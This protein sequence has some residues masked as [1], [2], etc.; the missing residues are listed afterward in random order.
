MRSIVRKSS[1]V[2]DTSSINP[3]SDKLLLHVNKDLPP[4]SIL[5]DNTKPTTH[6]DPNDASVPEATTM[7]SFNVDS[8][9]G[10]VDLNVISKN[11]IEEETLPMNM[12]ENGE[13]DTIN[14]NT[15]AE[16]GESDTATTMGPLPETLQSIMNNAD[17][18]DF[19]LN[20]I[21]NYSHKN[22]FLIL[23]CS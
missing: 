11:D 1:E 17:L 23:L 3:D 9:L 6:L 22:G 7:A 21:I 2:D 18:E 10:N 8:N 14:T 13:I 19:D 4:I 20:K 5:K 15:D 12:S 16:N